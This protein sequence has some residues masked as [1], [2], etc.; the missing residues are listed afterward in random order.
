MASEAL[1]EG[2][3]ELACEEFGQA[4]AALA[5][6]RRSAQFAF[7]LPILFLGLSL[8]LMFFP[9]DS[10]YP[11]WRS[12]PFVLLMV[13]LFALGQVVACWQYLRILRGR[14]RAADVLDDLEEG[15]HAGG[16]SEALKRVESNP[17]SHMRDVVG[18]WLRMAAQGETEGFDLVISNDS[19][20]RERATERQVAIHTALNRTTLKLGFLGT[21]IGL[22]QTFGP[23]RSAILALQGSEGDM[24]FVHDIAEAIKGDEYA[25]YTTLI[26]TGFSVF[27]ELINILFLERVHDSFEQVNNSLEQWNAGPLRY[28]AK[29]AARELDVQERAEEAERARREFA[30]SSAAAG[31]G[32]AGLPGSGAPLD[33]RSMLEQLARSQRLFQERVLEVEQAHAR[34]LEQLALQTE[35]LGADIGRIAQVQAK[36]GEALVRERGRHEGGGQG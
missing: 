7:T 24:K 30:E 33:E 31:I 4:R 36:V 34:M 14:R 3:E 15:L 28:L 2:I 8:W 13:A 32:V 27:M 19:Y 16:L 11:A 22:L 23:M 17:A 18:R 29:A 21:L 1:R 26:A 12:D 20:R 9:L 35:K 10:L 25:I 6:V 5:K